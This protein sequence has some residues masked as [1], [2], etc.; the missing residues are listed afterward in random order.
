MCVPRCHV[1]LGS[2]VNTPLITAFINLIVGSLFVSQM[3]VNFV[4]K[5]NVDT[6]RES[7][8]GCGVGSP[9]SKRTPETSSLRC[10]AAVREADEDDVSAAQMPSNLHNGGLHME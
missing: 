5:G 3:K 7:Q 2:L 4:A 10:A 8:F 1:S 6:W 9:G